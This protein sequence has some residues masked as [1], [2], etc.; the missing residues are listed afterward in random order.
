MAVRVPPV[1]RRIRSA[2]RGR[3]RLPA[4][5]SSR[6]VRLFAF[7]GLL[8]PGLIAANAGNDAGGIAT[9]SSVG[10]KYGY[11]LLWTMVLITI[12][13]AI[14][15]RLAARMGVVTGKGLAE[16]VREEY[17]IRWSVFATSAV[18]IANVGI[19]ISDFVGIGAAVGLTGVPVQISVPIAAVGIW[20][21]IVR[22]SYRSAERIFVWFTIPFFAYPVAAILAHPDWGDVGKAIAVPHLHTSPS[23]LVLLIALAGTTITP[24]MQLYL[25][26]AVVERGVREDDLPHEEREAVAGAVFA[27]LV[28]SFII[29]ATGATLFTHG[30]HDISSAAEAARALTPFAGHYAEAL[31]GIGLLGASLLAAAILPI[32]TS[33]VVSES[34]GYEKGVGR[35]RE[36]APV[37][38][39]IITGMI[40]LSAFVAMIPGLPVI[41]LLVGVQVVNGLLLPINLFFIWRLARSRNVMG[42]HR[43]RGMLDGAAAV[44]VAVTSTLSLALVAITVAG[45]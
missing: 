11:T 12:S 45:L 33:Y 31:F 20:L 30:I 44:T 23:F 38:V 35:R 21:I 40:M 32:A 7:L 10:A 17:G 34:L 37:F 9:Y 42:E 2:T 24:Y 6:R 18:L 43:S 36:E 29:I 27:N 14:V 5:L 25:Q 26:S 4:R 39:N 41:S 15:Q 28:A 1:M 16:L 8:G 3:P 13:L 19:C 22:G